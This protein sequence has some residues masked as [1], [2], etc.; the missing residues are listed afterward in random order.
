MAEDRSRDGRG[1]VKIKS[2]IGL[3][4]QMKD[5]PAEGEE[6]SSCS[7]VRMGE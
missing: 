1:T 2:Y 5:G 7:A 4:W 6:R 3:S